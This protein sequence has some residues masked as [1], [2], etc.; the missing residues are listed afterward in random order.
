MLTG[1]GVREIHKLRDYGAATA[2]Y[3]PYGQTGDTPPL[4]A[5]CGNSHACLTVEFASVLGRLFSTMRRLVSACLIGFALGA[6]ARAQGGAPAKVQP[7]APA[8]TTRIL[9]CP[10]AIALVKQ[11]GDIV[12]VPPKGAPERFVRDRS[13]CAFSEIAELRFLPT[14]D[15]PQCPVGYRCR[16]PGFEEWDW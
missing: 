6:P 8:P 2:E 4:P 13:F 15:N 10:E 16:E 5:G 1:F 14:R 7:R 3:L 11:Q 9:T 12:L